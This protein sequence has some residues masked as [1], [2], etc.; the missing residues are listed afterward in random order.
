MFSTLAKDIGFPTSFIHRYHDKPEVQQ[1]MCRTL[2]PLG[3]SLKAL[4]VTIV[5]PETN[6]NP[7]VHTTITPFTVKRFD[8]F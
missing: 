3:P 8:G 6:C 2:T 1:L 4:G 5:L 7:E